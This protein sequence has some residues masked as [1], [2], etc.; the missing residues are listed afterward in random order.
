MAPPF[1][2]ILLADADA[3]AAMAGHI[4]MAL[5]PGDTLLLQG[6]IGAGKTTFARALIRARLK[7]PKED[8]PSPT[9]TLVQTYDAGDLEIWH[10]DLYRLTDPQEVLEL[11][12]DD[13][14]I[15]AI[16]LIEWPDRLGPDLPTDALLCH[17]SAQTD[18]HALTLSGSARWQDLLGD[19]HV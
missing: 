14:F 19:L 18:H 7:S 10:C 9:F 2:R 4:A 6:D 5:G 13:A 11:G 12:L 16:C 17:F 3:T 1:K 15:G 8:V